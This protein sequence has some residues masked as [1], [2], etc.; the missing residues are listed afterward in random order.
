MLMQQFQ[1]VRDQYGSFKSTLNPQQLNVGANQLAE[2]DAGLGIIAE[3][4]TDYQTALANGQS[5]ITA[6]NNL[7]QVLNEAMGVWVQE[8]K[9]TCNQLRVGW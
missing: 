1:V 7:R 3:A 9:R 5:D 8:F 2:L 4:F 6:F